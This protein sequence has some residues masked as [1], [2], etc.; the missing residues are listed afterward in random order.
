LP[1]ASPT[2]D[3]SVEPSG[4]A[5]GSRSVLPPHAVVKV[6][7]RRIAKARFIVRLKVVELEDWTI[8]KEST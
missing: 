1:P 4:S 6:E 8:C 5:V 2:E 7:A 3:P